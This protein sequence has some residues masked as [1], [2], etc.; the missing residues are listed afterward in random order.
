MNDVMTKT[1]IVT[2][3]MSTMDSAFVQLPIEYNDGDSVRLEVS[4]TWHIESNASSIMNVAEAIDRE[5]DAV[6]AACVGLNIAEIWVSILDLNKGERCA[7]DKRSLTML[8]HG[9][10]YKLSGA[11]GNC[12]VSLAFAATGWASERIDFEEIQAKGYPVKC[13]TDMESLHVGDTI[14]INKHSRTAAGRFVPLWMKLRAFTVSEIIGNIVYI[15]HNG[16]RYDF[17]RN[18]V[19]KVDTST[20]LTLHSGDQLITSALTDSI[21]LP[22]Y[23]KSTSTEAVIMKFGQL[24]IFDGRKH[25]GKFRVTEYKLD[26][27]KKMTTNNVVGWVSEVD[28]IARGVYVK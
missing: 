14:K 23:L 11:L 8:L 25:N 28:I 3:V 21:T 18:T 24:F 5:V 12:N 7:L 6:K 16:T 19:S 22:V 2:C 27:T 10:M 1:T 20:K 26:S 15:E 17:L 4:P 13:K 9:Y